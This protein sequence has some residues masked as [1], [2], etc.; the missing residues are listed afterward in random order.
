MCRAASGN[1]VSGV[2]VSKVVVMTALTGVTSGSLPRATA[3]ITSRSVTMPSSSSPSITSSDPVCCFHIR[4]AATR[5]ESDRDSTT[6]ARDISSETCVWG[7][8]RAALAPELVAEGAASE[9]VLGGG[10][11]GLDLGAH[12]LAVDV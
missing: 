9:Q 7:G 2:T 6:L 1:E 5:S 10:R 3:F 8:E 12:F 11:M 4:V